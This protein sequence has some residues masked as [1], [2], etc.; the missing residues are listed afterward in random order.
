MNSFIEV[1]E[2]K[3]NEKILINTLLVI[4]VRENRITVANGFSINTYKTVETY[5][6]IKGKLNER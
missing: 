6:E 1:T 4:E 3:S 2:K 5:D